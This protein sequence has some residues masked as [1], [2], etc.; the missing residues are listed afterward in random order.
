M[1]VMSM[2]LALCRPCGHGVYFVPTAYAIFLL[3]ILCHCY[4]SC[5]YGMCRQ[6]VCHRCDF[7]V[8]L[9]PSL[10]VM[11]PMCSHY[12]HDVCAFLLC[13]FYQWCGSCAHGMFPLSRGML[14]LC[15]LPI[16]VPMAHALSQ[17][18]VCVCK[19]NMSHRLTTMYTEMAFRYA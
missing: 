19:V 11:C 18:C 5:A 8:Y 7:D 1:H 9:G 16:S 3:S 10:W 13:M 6:F 15:L 17:Q 4:V 2:V 12:A 14:T